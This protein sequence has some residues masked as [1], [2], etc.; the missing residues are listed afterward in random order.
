MRVF[1]GLPLDHEAKI[2]ISKVVKKVLSGHRPVKWEQDNKWHLTIAF[3]GEIKKEQVRVIEEAVAIALQEIKP[4]TVGFKGWGTFPNWLLPTVVWI[5]LNGDLKSM[6]RVYKNVREEL[7][8]I[9]F[10]F[11]NKAFIPHITLG[12]VKKNTS[13]KHRLELGKYLKKQRLMK[14]PQK[15][16]VDRLRIYE[17]NLTAQGSTYRVIKEIVFN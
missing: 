8:K 17:S 10:Q 2:G 6:A 3:L 13:R 1:I 16:Q 9:N 5:G 4:F 12:R 14:I 11:E 15:W 7:K